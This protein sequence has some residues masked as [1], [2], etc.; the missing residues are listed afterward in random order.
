VGEI[1]IESDDE[2]LSSLLVLKVWDT[3]QQVIM[4]QQETNIPISG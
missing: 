3:I 4:K 2:S 1:L